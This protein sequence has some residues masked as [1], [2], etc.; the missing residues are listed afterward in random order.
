MLQVWFSSVDDELIANHKRLEFKKAVELTDKLE[1]KCRDEKRVTSSEFTIIDG[2]NDTTLYVGVF[3]FGSYDY[4]N[5]YHQIKHKSTRIKVDKRNQ[6]D[7]EYLLEKIEEF[8]PDEYKR[9]EVIDKTLINLDRKKISRLKKWQRVTIYSLTALMTALFLTVSTVYVLEKI[10][11]ETVLDEGRTSLE[12]TKTLNKKYEKA[13]LGE[14]EELLEYLAEKELTENQEIFVANY[15]IYQGEY[16]SAVKTLNGDPVRAETMILAS[17]SY[18]T[19]ERI[20][21]IKEFNEKF[22]TNEARYDLAYFAK[23]Y[24]LMM[25]LPDVD[26]TIERSKMKTYAYMKLGKI[27]E[28]KGE[29]KN[30]NDTDMKQKIERYEVLKAEITT[31]EEKIKGEEGKKDKDKKIIETLNGEL[32]TKKEEFVSI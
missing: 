5:I 6:A 30:N 26:M 14:E 18:N 28:A 16:D 23:E 22:P 4:P 29:L 13:L 15:Y 2:R 11:Y 1:R 32:A 21:K 12:E 24:E 9:E 17:E 19:E 25:N 8:T 27:D 7:K 20:E 31:L 10:Q 3:D